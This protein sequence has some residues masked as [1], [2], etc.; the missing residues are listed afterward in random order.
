[1]HQIESTADIA[2]GSWL[3]EKL[4]LWINRGSKFGMLVAN[5]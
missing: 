5:I 3:K 2:S 1:M 4:K